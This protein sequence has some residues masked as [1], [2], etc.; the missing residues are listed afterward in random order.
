MT[1]IP[2]LFVTKALDKLASTMRQCGVLN[3]KGSCR[4]YQGGN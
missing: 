1:E 4:N 2:Q 3:D